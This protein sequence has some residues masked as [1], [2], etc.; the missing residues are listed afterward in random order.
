MI[1]AGQ[2]RR[3]VVHGLITVLPAGLWMIG[4]QHP[5]AA[6][7]IQIRLPGFQAPASDNLEAQILGRLSTTAQYQPD[8]LAILARLTVLESISMNLTRVIGP[9]VAGWLLVASAAMQLLAILL[10][11]SHIWPRV[12]NTRMVSSQ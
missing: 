5:V 9:L 11:V 1:R 12:R 6:Q 8:D 4:V 3:L 10:F 7:Q 2:L